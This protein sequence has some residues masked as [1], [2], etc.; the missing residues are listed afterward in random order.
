MFNLHRE[1]L[2]TTTLVG[3]LI[4]PLDTRVLEDHD[5]FGDD[6]TVFEGFR[7]ADQNKRASTPSASYT[8]FGLGRWSCPGR[9]FA[10][11][12]MAFPLPSPVL[13]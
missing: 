10:V 9:T 3:H 8:V 4:A 7:W 2:L 11:A 1:T 12:G 5:I 6:A 13:Y